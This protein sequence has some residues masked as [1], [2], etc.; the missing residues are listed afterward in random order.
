MKFGVLLAVPRNGA[1][2]SPR[3]LASCSILI[4]AFDTRQFY[5]KRLWTVQFSRWYIPYYAF[6]LSGWIYI[7][8]HRSPRRKIQKWT[9]AVEILTR[10]ISYVTLGLDKLK[11]LRY[12]GCGCHLAPF[13]VVQLILI[14]FTQQKI[15]HETYVQNRIKNWTLYLGMVIGTT[16]FFCW[17][18]N[19][20]CKSSL[21]CSLLSVE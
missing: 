17:F 11:V 4:G 15:F 10:G 9:L 21:L 16:C 2:K 5:W 13:H 18:L 20:T 6:P 14:R 1:R 3:N 19:W 7:C 8:S 12:K